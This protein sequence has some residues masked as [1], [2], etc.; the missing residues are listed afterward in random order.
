MPK[1]IAEKLEVAERAFGFVPLEEAEVEDEDDVGEPDQEE[2]G[3]MIRRMSRK[4]LAAGGVAA[5]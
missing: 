3:Q 2:N 1:K 5:G 4:R